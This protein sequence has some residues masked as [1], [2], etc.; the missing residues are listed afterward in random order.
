MQHHQLHQPVN[1]LPQ[2]ISVMFQHFQLSPEV[3]QPQLHQLLQL[4]V[5]LEY[6][7]QLGQ[8]AA[9]VIAVIL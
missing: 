8:V 3:A 2:H 4:D 1:G 5:P 7:P 6:S 9:L